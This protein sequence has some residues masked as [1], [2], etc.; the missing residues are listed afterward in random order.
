M[1]ASDL[2]QDRCTNTPRHHE[3]NPSLMPHQ[4]LSPMASY[5]LSDSEISVLVVD[6]HA[7]VYEGIIGLLSSHPWLRVSGL[8]TDGREALL[9]AK[10]L[11]PHLVIVDVNLPKL[12]GFALVKALKT[13]APLSKAIIFSMHS[14]EQFTLSVI[15][16]GV[17]GYVC[18]RDAATKL[19]KALEVVALGGTFFDPD[20][21]NAL[22]Q[23]TPE[24]TLQPRMT[25]REREVLVGVAEGLSNKEIAARLGLGVRTIETYRV[26]LVRKLNIRSAASLTRFALQQGLLVA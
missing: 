5:P 24:K 18:K 26:R 8:A 25:P 2:I 19:T 14:P 3:I 11:Q 4:T 17:R 16:S 13:E 10:E 15:E 23:A 21:A 9:K 20:F 7:I 1:V 12:S 6:D 22:R